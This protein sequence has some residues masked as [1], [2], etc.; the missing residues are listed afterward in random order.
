MS[1]VEWATGLI[2]SGFLAILAALI[3][4]TVADHTVEYESRVRREGYAVGIG[5]FGSALATVALV[6]AVIGAIR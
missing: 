3:L 1:I 2:A 6:L 4:Q 5:R